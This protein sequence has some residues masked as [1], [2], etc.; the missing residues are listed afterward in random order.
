MAIEARVNPGWVAKWLVMGSLLL[1]MGA[2]CLYDAV[3][4]YPEHNR[5]VAAFNELKEQGRLADW[6]TIAA[7]HGWSDA[8][9]GEPKTDLDILSQWIMLAICGPLGLAA[10]V[11]VA[12]HARRRITADEAGLVGPRGE[13]VP[14]G[15]IT[16]IDKERWERKGIAVVHYETADGRSLSVKIDDWVYRGA[17]EVLQEVELRTGLGEAMPG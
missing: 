4:A 5:R 10:I 2:W 7:E 9:P 13:R 12:L 15:R 14:Y 17:A 11:I 8:D 6:P 1:G 16:S 3:V